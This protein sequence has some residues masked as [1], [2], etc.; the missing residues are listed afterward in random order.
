M[1]NLGKSSPTRQ[2]PHWNYLRSLLPAD[3]TMSARVNLF[4]IVE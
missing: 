3:A 1:R 4:P 2:I